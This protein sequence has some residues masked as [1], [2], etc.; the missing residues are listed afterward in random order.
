MDG[1]SEGGVTG[2]R[3]WRR[4]P[5]RKLSE[6][7]AFAHTIGSTLKWHAKHAKMLQF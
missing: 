7:A 1:G 3:Q 5:F 2:G 6:E 4:F